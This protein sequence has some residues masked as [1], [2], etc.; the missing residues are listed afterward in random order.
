MNVTKKD[1]F[2][3][4]LIF[5]LVAAVFSNVLDNYFL[6]D[7][8]AMLRSIHDFR[9]VL[10]LFIGFR[11][12]PALLFEAVYAVWGTDPRGYYVLNLGLHAVNAILVYFVAS[13]L[14]SKDRKSRRPEAGF[15]SALFF[16]VTFSH[17]EGIYYIPGISDLVSGLFCL[18]CVF[19]V[20][21]YARE[22][23]AVSFF[24]FNFFFLCFLLSKP[25]AV[26][27]PFA[28]LV[29][30]RHCRLSA[31]IVLPCFVII[32]VY[33]FLPW[34][35]KGA[36]F[37]SYLKRGELFAFIPVTVFYFSDMLFS[38]IGFTSSALWFP[39][40]YGYFMQF[41]KPSVLMMFQ[42]AILFMAPALLF[43]F[44]L[45]KRNKTARKKPEAPGGETF[46]L[47]RICFL[48]S[49][50][51]LTIFLPHAF[52]PEL[53][54]VKPTL[55]QYRY[56]YLPV[57][58]FSM[59][60]SAVGLRVYNKLSESGHFAARMALLLF[61]CVIGVNAY[62]S[63][64][65]GKSLDRFSDFGRR[66]VESLSLYSDG[67][68]RKAVAAVLNPPM[69]VEIYYKTCITDMVAVRTGEKVHVAW[70]H[71]DGARQSLLKEAKR[72]N[73]RVF[74]FIVN[75]RGFMDVTRDVKFKT[76]K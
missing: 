12:I 57:C 51:M 39:F 20:L 28:L 37:S 3:P 31:K 35:E 1:F 19:Y 45:S 54:P 43:L 16:S 10:D 6:R 76:K 26:L 63:Y 68:S 59:L 60:V 7:E 62:E 11:L 42:C 72:M 50:F 53:Y 47:V 30:A 22:R 27:F 21:V 49:I 24:L 29:F 4:G 18:L 69:I 71:S 34:T 75:D 41:S 44:L 74:Y 5:L 25:T 17:H 8:T 40:P 38:L 73:A 14:L 15:L 56:L 61:F 65:F 67:S 46:P 9:A 55:I 70:I 58:F 32:I 2:Y 23:N 52:L 13:L 33:F 64:S 36:L 66:A 48:L